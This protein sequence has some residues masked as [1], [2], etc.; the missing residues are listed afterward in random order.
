VQP[1]YLSHGLKI[2]KA[3]KQAIFTA[4]NHAGKAA[5][6]MRDKAFTVAAEALNDHPRHRAGVFF[7]LGVNGPIDPFPVHLQWFG[8][9]GRRYG[10]F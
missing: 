5:S 8:F 4:S 9:T 6:Y 7:Y 2:L 3:D 1:I 10:R